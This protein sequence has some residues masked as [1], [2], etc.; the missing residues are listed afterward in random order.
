MMTCWPQEFG[1]PEIL[2]VAP[3]DSEVLGNARRRFSEGNVFSRYA[4]NP[5][6]AILARLDG[7]ARAVFETPSAANDVSG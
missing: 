4:W 2:P 1:Q 3:R 5:L 7:A 6:R